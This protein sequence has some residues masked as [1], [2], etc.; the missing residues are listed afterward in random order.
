MAR[1]VEFNRMFLHEGDWAI[2]LG[3]HTGDTA[4]PMAIAVGLNGGVLAFE[5]N[6]ATFALLSATATFNNQTSNIVPVPLAVGVHAR[7]EVFCYGDHWLDNGGDQMGRVK[8]QHGSAY[9]IPVKSVNLI[10]FIATHYSKVLTK[11][12]FIK[13]DCEGRDL[14]LLEDTM[15]RLPNTSDIC[16]QWEMTNDYCY[17]LMVEQLF[18]EDA[19]SVW[20]KRGCKLAAPNTSPRDASIIDVIALKKSIIIDSEIVI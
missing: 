1:E 14:S 17:W 5:P 2:D 18:S 10:E 15:K 8:W 12:K 16:F 19:H 20:I 6:P 3:A 4:G 13:F 9:S 7:D 11:L